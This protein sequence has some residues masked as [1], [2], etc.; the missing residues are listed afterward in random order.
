MLGKLQHWPAQGPAQQAGARERTA[1]LGPRFTG[2]GR[3]DN[4]DICEGEELGIGAGE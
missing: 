3:A 2:E 1:A 4:R